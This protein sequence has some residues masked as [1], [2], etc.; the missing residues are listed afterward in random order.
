MQAPGIM[1]RDYVLALNREADI[2][3]AALD[4]LGARPVPAWDGVL[5][6]HPEWNIPAT[7]DALLVWA[8]QELD[9]DLSLARAIV[10]FVRDHVADVSAE[11]FRRALLVGSMWKEL[12]NVHYVAREFTDARDAAQHALRTLGEEP[13]LIVDHA[14]ALLVFAQISHELGQT[15]EALDAIDHA[16]EVF[17]AHAEPRRELQALQIA[18]QILM[19]QRE[20]ALAHEIY[21]I[22]LG[23]AEREGG[24]R[25]VARA[26]EN[27]GVCLMRLGHL[28]DACL[29]LTKALDHFEATGMTGEVHRA[30]WALADIA[31]ERNELVEALQAL[32]GV[33]AGFLHRGMFRLA[34]CVLVEVGD[35][36][37]AINGD[38]VYARELVAR[39]LTT[40]GSVDAPENVRDAVAYLARELAHVQAREQMRSVF[41]YVR[42]F[43]DQLLGSPSMAFAQ[44]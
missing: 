19:D 9:S 8:N 24:D 12:A 23:T 22:A 43:L 32:H 13:V 33:Y 16:A 20:Y 40:L 31:R 1:L 37:L 7:F 3:T 34:T 42:T 36:V 5:R 15:V 4:A 14:V 6:Q 29:L 41:D 28:D 25:D 11:G 2:A 44:P 18:G 27:L 30:V 39:L 35:T 21:L 38:S 17:R 26:E 10:T